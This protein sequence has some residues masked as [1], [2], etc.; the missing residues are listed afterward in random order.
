MAADGSVVKLLDRIQSEFEDEVKSHLQE[1][2]EMA[3]TKNL[4]VKIGMDRA[5]RLTTQEINKR[6]S[7][8]IL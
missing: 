5:A 3:I 1:T 7:A 8:S 6:L 4:L 2:K